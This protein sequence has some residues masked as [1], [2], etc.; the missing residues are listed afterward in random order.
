MV[1]KIKQISLLLLLCAFIPLMFVISA[2]GDKEILF[3]SE[4]TYPYEKDQFGWDITG[5]CVSSA[6]TDISGD[7]VIPAT[8][9]DKKV[10]AI[11]VGVFN[12]CKDITSITIPEGVLYIGNNTFNSNVTIYLPSTLKVFYGIDGKEYYYNGTY[13][14][15]KN[16]KGGGT[17]KPVHLTDGDL[18]NNVFT[19]K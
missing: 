6:S 19:A 14:E 18:V 13:A 15:W 9:D 4:Y 8:Y 16:I 11:E 5:Y 2:C 3:Y 10:I 17:T 12:N 1:K 7:V